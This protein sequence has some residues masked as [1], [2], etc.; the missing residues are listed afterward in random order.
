M[1]PLETRQ[2]YSRQDVILYALAL[3]VG[4]R[5][6]VEPGTLKFV[7]ENGLRALPTLPLVL[8]NARG[9]LKKPEFG[10]DATR[11]V[12]GEQS[13]EVFGVLP[14]EG[15][16]MSLFSIDG[17]EDKGLNKAAVI[18]AT[19]KIYDNQGGVHVATARQSYFL[20]GHGGFSAHRG[21]VGLDAPPPLGTVTRVRLLQAPT[22]SW[23]ALLYRLCGDF[24]PLHADPQVAEAA[25]FP[26]PILHGLCTFGIVAC[27]LLEEFGANQPERLHRLGAR[28][29]GPVFPGETLEID[30]SSD[31]LGGISFRARV[32]TR[33]ALVL[34]RGYARIAPAA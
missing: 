33:D 1:R 24:N 21:T 9:W 20:R 30:T 19:R 34:D 8:A 27:R 13:L 15:T 10:I 11:L 29:T 18:Y 23:Q 7:L 4:A 26:K 28:F 32:P 6:V 31:A 3:G 17:I 22:Y 14:P 16:A 2:D 25:G 12:H 5:A